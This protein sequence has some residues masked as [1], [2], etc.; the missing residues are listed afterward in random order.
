M[1]TNQPELRRFQ[2]MDRSIREDVRSLGDS[3]RR[4]HRSDL[5]RRGA[6][7]A[8]GYVTG[9]VNAVLLVLAARSLEVPE[10][11]RERIAGCIDVALLEQWLARAASASSIA[12][13]V[14]D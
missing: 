4:E 5:F 9:L 7:R 11:V 14:D 2:E 13:V 3:L 8:D 12:E 1:A 6:A 10:G